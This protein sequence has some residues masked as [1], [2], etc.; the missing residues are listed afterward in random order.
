MGH[1]GSEDIGKAHI[2]PYFVDFTDLKP[3]AQGGIEVLTALNP[4][5]NPLW[6]QA[7]G[8]GA[9]SSI[10]FINDLSVFT[11]KVLKFGGSSLASTARFA[12][13]AH[14]V[15]QQS[16]VEPL[17][18]VL[19][20]PH[21][22]TNSLL[23]LVEQARTGADCSADLQQLRNRL[24]ELVEAAEAVA[25]RRH[26]STPLQD[27]TEQHLETI[28]QYVQGIRLLSYCPDSIQARILG[29]GEQ[30]SVRLMQALLQARQAR[31]TVL[32]AAQLVKSQGDYLNAVADIPATQAAFAALD[33]QDGVDIRIMAGFVSSSAQRRIG[34]A[35][36]QR[37]GL[38]SG[39]HR[40]RRRAPVPAKSGPMS[41]ACTAPI[42]VRS[43]TPN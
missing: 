5:L 26:S 16:L 37:L 2:L 17:I 35:G 9:Y 7:H 31:C 4:V 39:D 24:Q 42:R 41:T 43:K 18:L 36:P 11:M 22:V 21:G 30:F 10:R 28:G 13:V 1:D 12:E 25:G 23:R 6:C 38:F 33:F 15:H 27:F 32:D 29:A 3:Y 8:E 19:S 34:P 20:A 14:I 40:G